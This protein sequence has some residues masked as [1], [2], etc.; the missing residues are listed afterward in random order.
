MLK[1]SFLI[2][3]LSLLFLHL[4]EAL[5]IKGPFLHFKDSIIRVSFQFDL[6]AESAEEIRKGITKEIIFYIDLFRLWKTWP[7]EFIAGRKIVRKISSDP[8][9]K[10]YIATSFDGETIVEKRFNSFESMMKWAL[11][12]DDFYLTSLKGMPAGT[13]FVRTTVESRLRNI[14]SLFSEIFFFLP[15]REF[16]VSSDSGL[17]VWNESTL[18]PLR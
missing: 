5:E 12:F 1:R 9:K 3:V 11:S 4:A 18:K 17:F 2:I 15:D 7:D 6:D 8:M 16:K 14:P 13:Y 10:E